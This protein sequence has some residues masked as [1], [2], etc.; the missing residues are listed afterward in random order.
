MSASFAS[1]WILVGFA[2]LLQQEEAAARGQDDGPVYQLERHGVE[3]RLQEGNVYNRKL[4][5]DGESGIL[6]YGYK[7][8]PAVGA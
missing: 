5:Q 1:I 4:Q 3:C 7:F 8:V 2:R 6:C